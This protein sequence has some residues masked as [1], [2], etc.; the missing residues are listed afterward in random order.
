[1]S[2]HTLTPMEKRIRQARRRLFLQ[3]LLNRLVGCWVV[4]L[5][6]SLGWFLLQPLVLPDAK[7]LRWYVLGGLV[8]AGALAALVWA[9]RSAPSRTSAALTLDQRF[10]LRERVTTALSLAPHDLSSPAGQALLADA[11]RHMEKLDLGSRFP[12]RLGRRSLLIPAQALI[13]VLLALF[14]QPVLSS[15]T[16][17]AG[18]NGA[19][20]DPN[21]TDRK[22]LINAQANNRPP[23]RKPPERANKSEALKELEAELEKLYGDSSK[24]D[25]QEKPEQVREKVEQLTSAEER[26]KKLEREQAE[27]FQRLQEQLQKLSGMDKD[28]LKEDGPLREFHDAL[29]KG[30]VEKAKEELDKLQKKVKEKKL[31][32]KDAE[33]LK[34]QMKEMTEKLERVAKNEEQQKKLQ[35]LIKKAKEEGRDAESLERELKR[36]HEEAEKSKEMQ[37]LAKKLGDCKKCLEQ[38]DFDGL[39][40]KL[41][42]LS[43]DMQ[44]M[45]DKLDDLDDLDEHLQNLK[46]M[47]KRL[48]KECQGEGKE[49]SDE[50]THKDDADWSPFTNPASGRR[51]ENPDAKT[52]EGDEARQRGRFD[53]RGRKT[54]AGSI[55]GPAFTKK[56]SVEMA[57]EIQQAVQEAGEAME[58]QNLP[59]AAQDMV[60]EY[61]EKLGGEKP[62]QDK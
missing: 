19:K 57:G 42:E 31:S 18:A 13:I 54:Y 58:V 4:A 14:Y 16:A 47:R 56:S 35:D 43:K 10:E 26:L 30:D 40:D 11:N 52:G 62:K 51:K 46:E 2:S 48:C 5:A 6:L 17:E 7:P 3:T 21:K 9:I 60:R 41:G 38:N 39:A 53:P 8:G 12:L 24:T 59:K 44:G 28:A 36:L 1:M 20:K 22:D 45:M 23:I 27:K 49:R 33:Q 32:D 55:Q 37:N 29:S 61:F 34:Q 15:S 25:K 50:W